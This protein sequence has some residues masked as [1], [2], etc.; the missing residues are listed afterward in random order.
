MDNPNAEQPAP[1]QSD[2]D[3][4][5]WERGRLIYN[6]A[7]LAFTPVMVVIKW[8][9]SQWLFTADRLGGYVAFAVIANILYCAAYLVELL[10]QWKALRPYAV[11]VRRVVLVLGTILALIL[12]GV[13][14]MELFTDP[15]M[16][17]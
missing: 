3:V 10:L 12:A 11:W 13:G 8:P 6:A 7:Q 5:F 9:E 16:D 14:L 15:S 1:P 2:F 17:Q 4:C